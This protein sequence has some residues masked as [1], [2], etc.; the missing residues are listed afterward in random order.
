[1]KYNRKSKYILT[2]EDNRYAIVK[3]AHKCYCIRRNINGCWGYGEYILDESGT[4]AVF[5]WQK[6]AK[7]YIENNLYKTDD[8]FIDT[9]ELSFEISESDNT[10]DEIIR[11]V[12]SVYTDFKFSRTETRYGSCLMAIFVR[13]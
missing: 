2:T 4:P 13:R 3:V 12:E 8:R 11:K 7:E 10:L 6:T 1:M 9:A 5:F